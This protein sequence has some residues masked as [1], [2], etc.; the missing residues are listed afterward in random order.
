MPLMVNT[1]SFSGTVR[2]DLV[3]LLGGVL[4]IVEIGVLRRLDQGEQDAL[5]L[6]RRELLLRRHVHEAGRGDHADEHEQR[7]RPVVERAVQPALIALL[8]PVEHAVEEAR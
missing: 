6:L 1:C 7:H 4:E 8:Q 2:V 3:E 5:V